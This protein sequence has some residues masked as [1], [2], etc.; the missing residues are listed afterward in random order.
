VKADSYGNLPFLKE[1]SGFAVVEIQM[2]SKGNPRKPYL[3]QKSVR[4]GQ[5]HVDALGDLTGKTHFNDV[6]VDK[7]YYT[8][9][10]F[11]PVSRSSLIQL[12]VACR[13]RRFP[14][15]FSSNSFF[16]SKLQDSVF[17]FGRSDNEDSFLRYRPEE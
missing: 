13:T 14:R 16:Y 10:N 15:G 7:H 12:C 4:I 8:K 3:T 1:F 6:I 11:V 9:Y 17:D 2:F 5:C